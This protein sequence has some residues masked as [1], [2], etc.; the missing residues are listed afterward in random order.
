MDSKAIQRD[1]KLIKQAIEPL[2]FRLSHHKERLAQA[3]IYLDEVIHIES[4]KPELVNGDYGKL[5]TKW[6]VVDGKVHW[7]DG[8]VSELSDMDFIKYRRGNFI[9]EM[10]ERQE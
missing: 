5:R 1:I 4:K 7:E 3:E 9:R 6:V 8:I 2:E 10:E